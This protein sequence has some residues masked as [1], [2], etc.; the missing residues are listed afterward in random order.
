MLSDRLREIEQS[1]V[2]AGL[3]RT[4]HPRQSTSAVLDLASNDY[5]G[6]SQHPEV[7]AAAQTAAADWGTGSTG[8]RLVTGTTQLHL[9]FESRIAQFVGTES[10]LT[11]SSG[12]LANIGAITA[13]A[14]EDTLIVSDQGNHAS[15]IDAIRMSRAQVV[16]V[17][18]GDVAAMDRALSNNDRSQAMVVTDGVFSVDGD[19]ADIARIHKV[20]ARHD[21]ILVVDEAHCLGVVGPGG[22]GV[23]ADAQVVDDPNVVITATL[24]KSFG[25]QGGVVLGS[26]AVT[27]HLVDRARTFIFDTG[28]SPM[29]VGAA[30]AALHIIETQ[31]Q[32]VEQVQARAIELARIADSAGWPTTTPQA[33]VISALVG[34]PH[35]AV[36]AARICR[37]LGNVHVGCFRPPSV[38]EGRSCLRMTARATLT[39]NDLT[40]VAEALDL[41]REAISPLDAQS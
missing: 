19:R 32:I 33:A 40:Q 15:L 8:S 29:C 38:P 39:D 20:T 26:R 1:R 22:R 13:L 2:L 36:E 11:F 23:C 14:D 30:H 28:L 16:V 41:A 4:L 27:D 25:T 35:D 21:A 18:H 31:P 12:Y 6:L 5:L 7:I 34:D 37:E 9:D 3:R 10:A 24:S 17:D